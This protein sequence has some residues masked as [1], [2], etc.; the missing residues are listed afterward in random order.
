M[1][2]SHML[3]DNT[4]INWM[5]WPRFDDS[6]VF[7]G[8]LDGEKGGSFSLLPPTEEFRV[9]NNTMLKIPMYCVLRLSYAEGSYRVTDFAPRFHQYERYYKP[10][11]AG[12]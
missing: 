1:P 3:K 10:L 9:L 2:I 12:S 7:G 8:L 5:C 6:F 11:N 4:N